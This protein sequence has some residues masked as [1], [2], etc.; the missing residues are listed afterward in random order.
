[1]ITTAN[2][3]HDTAM[4]SP[5]FYLLW[6]AVAGNAIGG[7]TVMSCAKTIMSDTFGTALPTIVTGGFAAGYVAAL[8][9]VNMVGRLG[10][11][12]VSDYLGRKNTYMTF[13]LGIPILASLPSLTNYM[14][15]K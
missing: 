4:R 14:L 11:A 10:W 7:V 1:M 5:Q 12:A 9:G 8:S 15:E 6:A 13:G 3:H 2:V